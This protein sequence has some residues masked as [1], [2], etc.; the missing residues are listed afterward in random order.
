MNFQVVKNKELQLQE[1]LINEPKIILADE[2][3]GSLDKK[4]AKEIF[5]LLKKQINQKKINNICNS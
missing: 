1:Q 3:T 4:T 2:P 5:K